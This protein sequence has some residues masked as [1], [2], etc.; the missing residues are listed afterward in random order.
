MGAFPLGMLQTA[1]D[2]LVAR[3]VDVAINEHSH[4]ARR[5]VWPSPRR[6]RQPLVDAALDVGVLPL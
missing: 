3:G 5:G 6:A 1:R 4:E 2:L